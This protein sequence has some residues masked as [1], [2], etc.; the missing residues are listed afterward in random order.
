MA[1]AP[2]TLAKLVRWNTA[3]VSGTL[4]A[5]ARGLLCDHGRMVIPSGHLP[6]CRISP[7]GS[8]MAWIDLGTLHSLPPDVIDMTM[9]LLSWCTSPARRAMETT[10]IDDFDTATC[11]RLT[12][13]APE[14][15][16]QL[17][18]WSV[19]QTI[20]DPLMWW[21]MRPTNRQSAVMT[22]PAVWSSSVDTVA[23]VIV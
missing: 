8:L 23:F 19:C 9:M 6:F 5:H 7:I 16:G 20:T 4:M 2:T 17:Q 13:L 11:V 12:R 1:D 18:A 22:M 14:A 21:E 3:Q 15:A 10:S